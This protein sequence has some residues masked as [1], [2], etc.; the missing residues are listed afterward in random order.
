MIGASCKLCV[1]GVEDR[2]RSRRE[3]GSSKIEG[4]LCGVAE[5]VAERE[6]E[7]EEG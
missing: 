7:E 2:N 5:K 3:G 6:E 1:D 4:W